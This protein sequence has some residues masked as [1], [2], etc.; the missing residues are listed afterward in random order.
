MTYHKDIKKNIE[1]Y[2]QN[3]ESIGSRESLP[4]KVLNHFERTVQ[5]LNTINGQKPEDYKHLIEYLNQEGRNFGWS[6]P[7]NLE[8]EKCETEFWKLKDNIK[9]I[10]QRMNV[11]ERLFFFGY[12]ADYD[13]LKPIERSAR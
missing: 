10:V 13:N 12:L 11:N 9:S 3:L 6:Y 7:E 1:S 4:K 2:V 5:I 8:E